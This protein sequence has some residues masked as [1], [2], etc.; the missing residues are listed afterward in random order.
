MTGDRP[1]IWRDRRSGV[2]GDLALLAERRAG[3]AALL[4]L[5][6]LEEPGPGLADYVAEHPAIAALA[7]AGT[8]SAT[9]YERIFLR[10][11]PLYESVF[12]SDDGQHGGDV[13]AEVVERYALVRFDEHA[14]R[15]WRI[16]GPDHLGMELRCYATLCHD[17]AVA[18][19][20]EVPDVAVAAVETERTFLADHLSVWAQCAIEATVRVA[21]RSAYVAV[22]EAID[23][24]LGEEH[25]RLRPRPRLGAGAVAAAVGLP[26]NVG[27]ARLARLLLA[28]ATCG[29]WLDGSDIAAAAR[30]IGAP[31]RASDTRSGLRQL[32][33][34]ADGGGELATL[35][36]PLREAVQRAGARHA[37]R[38]GDEPGNEVTWRSWQAQAVAMAALLDEIVERNRL[39]APA[40]EGS[41]RLTVFGADPS[42]LADEID[43]VVA[44]L[45]VNGWRVERDE[46]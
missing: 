44:T 2:T 27:P 46:R 5:L 25:E 20:D 8:A 40:S 14:E 23:A 21:G 11:V 31:W 34:A 10:G 24:F 19:R 22:L 18:W 6:V 35:L 45:R 13:L 38:A 39:A 43:A 41:E 26:G 33:E 3:L 42:A 37:A 4:G 7:S 17:E 36:A 15:R 28:P 12:R 30:A 29:A 1:A 16:A 9:E 32:I